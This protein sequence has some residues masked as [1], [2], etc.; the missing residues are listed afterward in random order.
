VR[1]GEIKNFTGIDH[2]FEEPTN[3]DIIVETDK[4]T[5]VKSKTII[6]KTFDR[7]GYLPS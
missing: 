7:M 3:P 5:V 6:I 2:P 1:S 4:Q